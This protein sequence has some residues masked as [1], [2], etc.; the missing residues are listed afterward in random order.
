MTCEICGEEFTPHGQGKR[1][2]CS[3]TC[4]RAARRFSDLRRLL[5]RK[6]GKSLD[7]HEFFLELLIYLFDDEPAHRA[8]RKYHAKALRTPFE[9]MKANFQRMFCKEKW[10]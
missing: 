8:L 6:L 5:S 3:A 2:Y 7:G 1:K 9:I 10:K 4:R